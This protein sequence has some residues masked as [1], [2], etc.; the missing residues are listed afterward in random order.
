M[1]MLY[2]GGSA[3]FRIAYSLTD[4]GE[5][6]DPTGVTLTLRH[7]DTDLTLTPAVENTDVGR[8]EASSAMP[9]PGWWLLRWATSGTLPAVDEAK[10]LVTKSR[11]I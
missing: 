11:V 7:Q 8:Y 5:A 4:T 10:F 2:E 9:L 6:Y 1:S 3:T